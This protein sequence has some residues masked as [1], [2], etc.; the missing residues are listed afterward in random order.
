MTHRYTK[1]VLGLF[2][3]TLVGMS[4]LFGIASPVQANVNLTSFD[5]LRGDSTT[6]LI[7]QWETESETDMVGFRIKRGT[8]AALQQATDVKTLPNRGSATTG[9]TYS[10]TDS[11]LTTGQ[12]YYYWLYELKSDGTENLL[13]ESPDSEAPGSGTSPTNTPTATAT[14]VP[15]QQ[16]TSTPTTFVG[17]PAQPTSTPTVVQEANP[18]STPTSPPANATPTSTS[19]PQPTNTPSDQASSPQA[20]STPVPVQ[21]NQATNTPAVAVP[22]AIVEGVTPAA[23]LETPQA[24]TTV[25]AVLENDRAPANQA[26]QELPTPTQMPDVD[27]AVTVSAETTSLPDGAEATPQALAQQAES[28][29]AAPQE[30]LARPTATPRPSADIESSDNSGS[31]LLIFG[32][33]SLCGA[34]VLALAAVVIWRR[35]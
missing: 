27:A 29:A 22:T 34:V 6:A 10:E 7:V 3:L 12:T 9:A 28:G 18:T 21:Q 35:R 16:P 25:A 26:L 19:Q 13:T 11:G 17:V 23:A 5:V 2:A 8:S 24:D 30:R 32:G 31:L 33:A 15:Q 4:S 20:T 1:A 14:A